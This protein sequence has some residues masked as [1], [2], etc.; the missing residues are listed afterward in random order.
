MAR[1]KK[2]ENETP[3]D[4]RI[5][6]DIEAIS[7]IPNRS[8]KTAWNRRMDNMVKLLARLKPYEEQIMTLMS[9]KTVILDEVAELRAIMVQECIHPF[10]MLIHKGDHVECKFCMA[11]LSIPKDPK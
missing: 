10:E 1:R 6:R 9:E 5:R 7:N 2:P 4:T 11:K 3:E 8:D